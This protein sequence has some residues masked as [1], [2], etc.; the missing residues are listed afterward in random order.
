MIPNPQF[1]RE[2]CQYNTVFN[3]DNN[4]DFPEQLSQ[5]K[6]DNRFSIELFRVGTRILVDDIIN[7]SLFYIHSPD[8]PNMSIRDILKGLGYTN[9]RIQVCNTIPANHS[10]QDALDSPAHTAPASQIKMYS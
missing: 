4:N 6:L 10:E 3:D 7:H 9:H 5:I 1:I 2:N 8:L